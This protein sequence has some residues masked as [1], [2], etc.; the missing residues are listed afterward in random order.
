MYIN[1]QPICISRSVK[2]VHTQIIASCINMQL[3]IVF[4]LIKYFRHASSHNVH[5]YQLFRKFGSVNQSKTMHTN[6]CLK[7]RKLHKFATTNKNLKSIHFR[8]ASSMY[9][10]F[11]QNLAS[12]YVKT[13]HTN[14]L[15]KT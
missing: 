3:P 11:Q 9:I 6:L 8:H 2:V 12:R 15:A 5:V 10:I 7:N 1:F 13:V 14:L 4:F